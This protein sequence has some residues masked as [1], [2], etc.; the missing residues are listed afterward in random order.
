MLLL[1]LLLSAQQSAI[2]LTNVTVIDVMTGA[3]APGSTV[4]ISGARISAVGPVA[5]VP[6]PSGARRVEG[7]GRF[8]VPGLWDMHV[9]LSMLGRSGLALFLANGITG[10][11]DMGGDVSRVIPWRDSVARGTM[12]GPR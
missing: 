1:A 4:L 9:H 11:R 3:R 2:A 10:V 6:I 5:S 8:V 12:P 7:A